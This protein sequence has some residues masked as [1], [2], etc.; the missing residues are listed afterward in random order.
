M[1]RLSDDVLGLVS[2]CLARLVFQLLDEVGGLAAGLR[3]KLTSKGLFSF[4]DGHPSQALQLP[5][6]CGH[7]LRIAAPLSGE[8]GL[9]RGDS[10]LSRPEL[11][12]RSFCGGELRRECARLFGE[13]CLGRGELFPTCLGLR[14]GCAQEVVSLLLGGQNDFFLPGFGVS[15]AIPKQ[16]T[17]V[18]GGLCEGAGG[19]F[20]R[21]EPCQDESQPSR[22]PYN[23][24]SEVGSDLAH[25]RALDETRG[26]RA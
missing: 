5:L 11:D 22:E 6:L 25:E 4:V 24:D 23:D 13:L 18:L 2:G 9:L 14:L 16:A 17:S 20:L 19:L 10:L 26:D 1:N 3:F 12:R 7:E 21:G 15:L 8:S